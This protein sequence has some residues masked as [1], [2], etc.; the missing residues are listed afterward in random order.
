MEDFKETF[1]YNHPLSGTTPDYPAELVV[2]K[3]PYAKNG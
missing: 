1:I 2:R 3:R